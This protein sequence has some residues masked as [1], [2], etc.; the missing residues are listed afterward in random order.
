M[1]F[2]TRFHLLRTEKGLSQLQGGINY[3]RQHDDGCRQ[4]I[5]FIFSDF[6][7]HKKR[8]RISPGPKI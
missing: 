7:G 2:A 5:K 1:D 8:P 4:R 3:K 6:L